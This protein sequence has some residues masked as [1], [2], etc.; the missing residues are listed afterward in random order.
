[1]ASPESFLASLGIPVSD[2]LKGLSSPRPRLL[3]YRCLMVLFL[4]PPVSFY[5]RF[6]LA[7]WR[8]KGSLL[9]FRRISGP[10]THST[11]LPK[12]A[13]CETVHLWLICA[14]VNGMD[15]ADVR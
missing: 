13:L 10:G 2:E 11:T 15:V 5:G 4:D 6:W 7:Y 12:E 9:L 14:G 3:P 1:M 8:I